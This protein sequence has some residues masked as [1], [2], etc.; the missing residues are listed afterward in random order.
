VTTRSIEHGPDEPTG[1]RIGTVRFHRTRRARTEVRQHDRDDRRRGEGGRDD[2]VGRARQCPDG[3]VGHQ[4]C[5]QPE[6]RRQTGRDPHSYTTGPRF[7]S[8]IGGDVGR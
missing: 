3:V 1:S 2:R 7:E 8:G 6:G 5:R 4:R